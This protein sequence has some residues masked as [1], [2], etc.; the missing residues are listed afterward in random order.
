MIFFCNPIF[1]FLW[2]NHQKHFYNGLA[3]VV[4]WTNWILKD[5][6]KAAH[7]KQTMR[8][9]LTWDLID[10]L[11]GGTLFVVSQREVDHCKS[12]ICLQT[13][14][15][16]RVSSPWPYQKAKCDQYKYRL[17]WHLA[18]SFFYFVYL[19][20]DK[21][22]P[23]AGDDGVE[24]RRGHV[25]PFPPLGGRAIRRR[26]QQDFTFRSFNSSCHYN[27]GNV[28]MKIC[29]APWGQIGLFHNDEKVGESHKKR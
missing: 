4:P 12:Y 14:G 3:W 21:G 16:C 15:K 7:W 6:W 8:W 27:K 9:I 11:W 5:S 2:G 23:G 1:C 29:N 18:A 19:I 13:C 26:W 25:S 22:S 10:S 17:S 28:V 24:E 20:E